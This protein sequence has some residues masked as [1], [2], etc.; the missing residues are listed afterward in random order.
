MAFGAVLA[1]VWPTRLGAEQ[2]LRGVSV[3]P[4]ARLAAS[5][6]GPGHG[7]MGAEAAET[8][9]QGH[10]GPS[11]TIACAMSKFSQ[12]TDSHSHCCNFEFPSQSK[13]VY[14]PQVSWSKLA[15]DLHI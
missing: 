11:W 13:H 8:L 3:Q 10:L 6:L 5:S 1:R 2:V 14:K 9:C 4:P 15:L 12:A 7:P